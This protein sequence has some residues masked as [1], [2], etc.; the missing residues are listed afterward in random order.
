VVPDRG[1]VLVIEDPLSLLSLGIWLFAAGMWPVAFLFGAC[2]ACCEE[3]CQVSDGKPRT[4]PKNEGTWIPS[5][6]WATQSVL[7]TFNATP[8]DAETWFFYGSAASSKPGGGATLA[9]QRDWW[10]ICNWYSSKTNT[11]G[12]SPSTFNPSSLNKRA[13][14]LPS[15]SGIVHVYTSVTTESLG[16]ATIGSIYFWAGSEHLDGSTIN[17]TASVFDSLYGAAFALSGRNSGVINNGSVFMGLAIND[18]TGVVSGGATLVNSVNE[19]VI[20]G[21]AD[22][23]STSLNGADGPGI[24]SGGATFSLSNNFGTVNDGAVFSNGSFQGNLGVVNGG[25]TFN[26]TSCSFKFVGSFFSTPCTRRFVAHPTD[27]P[28]CNGTAPSGCVNAEN[29]CGCG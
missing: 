10:N 1:G 7:W 12:N 17:T 16:P 19:G 13:T 18:V 23:S 20:N 21:G 28:T 5:G 3:S 14:R 15:S 29:N 26:D 11:P 25:A 2:S 24:V 4:D 22:F 6:S 9:E 8:G 27:L